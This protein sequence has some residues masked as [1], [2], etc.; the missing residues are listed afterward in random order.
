[1]NGAGTYGANQGGNTN[2]NSISSIY[3]KRNGHGTTDLIGRMA[4]VRKSKKKKV[5][6]IN[7][8]DVSPKQFKPKR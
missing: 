3:A 5:Q 7:I 6:K 1:M 2:L 4:N 8:F